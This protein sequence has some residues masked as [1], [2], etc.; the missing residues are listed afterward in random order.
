M[1]NL[2]GSIDDTV[3][4]KNIQGFPTVTS[5]IEEAAPEKW[6]AAL[7]AAEASYISSLQLSGFSD[8]AAQTL[9]ASIIRRLKGQLDGSKNLADW[10]L[11]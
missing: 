5:A 8:A 2:K 10:Q 7:E 4:E 1:S 9:A 11:F 3:L 6:W